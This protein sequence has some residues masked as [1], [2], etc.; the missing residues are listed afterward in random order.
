MVKKDPCRDLFWWK[1]I[2]AN[3]NAEKKKKIENSYLEEIAHPSPFP[4]P[5]K[6]NGP[7]LNQFGNKS[8]ITT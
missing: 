5:R 7:S 1:Q 4:P 2:P 3:S 6:L 8:S